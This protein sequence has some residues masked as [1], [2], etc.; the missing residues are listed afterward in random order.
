MLNFFRGFIRDWVLI[1]DQQHI[2]KRYMTSPWFYIDVISTVPWSHITAGEGEDGGG[3]VEGDGDG[4]GGGASDS[5]AADMLRR[6]KTARI[7]RIGRLLRLIRLLRM[8]KLGVILKKLETYFAE[9]IEDDQNAVVKHAC[10][11]ALALLFEARGDVHLPD[12]HRR[13]RLGL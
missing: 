11:E 6:A 4:G 5:E 2:A 7:A 9:L 13:L 10:R 1:L 8:A 12:P 3:T